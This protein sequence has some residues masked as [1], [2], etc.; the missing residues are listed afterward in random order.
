[1]LTLISTQRS[2]ARYCFTAAEIYMS[3]RIPV[4]PLVQSKFGS[5][6]FFSKLAEPWTGPKVRFGP[7]PEPWTQVQSG[8]EVLN[9]TFTIFSNGS[10]KIGPAE[11]N[12]GFGSAISWTLNR[13]FGPVH[14]VQVRIEVQNRT[15]TTL[16]KAINN[17]SPQAKLINLN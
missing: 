2:R 9:R 8:S 13:T 4:S 3:G 5:V 12:F 15:T 16:Y 11:P 10:T 7:F 1:M 6:R 14:K 17:I